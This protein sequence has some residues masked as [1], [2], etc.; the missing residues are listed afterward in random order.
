MKRRTLAQT[1]SKSLRAVLSTAPN[2][3]YDQ[4]KN[5][6]RILTQDRS[7]YLDLE[8]EYSDH[9]LLIGGSEIMQD[10]ERP[11]MRALAEEAASSGGHILEVGFGMG[12]SAN[13]LIQAGCSRYT[14]IE[15]HK[16]VLDQ[17]RKWAQGQPVPVEAVEG[18]WEDVIDGLGL[19]D[20]IL[21]DT[22][23]V[24][25][26]D[27]ER[28]AYLPFIQK[29]SEHLKPGGVFT[30]YTG[31]AETLPPE[32]MDLLKR[33]FSQLRTYHVDGLKPPRSCQYW[34][35]SRMVVPVCVK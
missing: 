19:F 3:W 33:F 29:A 22:Y 26:S 17:F 8:A 34:H 13:F 6:N 28:K 15:P 2:T 9:E 30:F 27:R 32:H 24:S 11:L 10:W 21:F 18:F 5:R 4:W 25:S 7:E 20:G 35:E 12:I 31:Y 16:A 1:V 23:P 14:V